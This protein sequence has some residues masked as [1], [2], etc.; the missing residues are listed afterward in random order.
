MDRATLTK[1]FEPFF[2]TKPVDKGTGLG[3]SQVYGFAKQS[4]GEIN[5]ESALG[6][7][8]TFT[9]YLPRSTSRTLPPRSQENES[10][11]SAFPRRRILLVEDNEAVGAFAADLLKELGQVVRWVGDGQSALDILRQD[12]ADYDLVFSDVVMPGISGIEL[13][14]AIA[15]EWPDLEVI[16]TSG[17]SH[18]LAEEGSFGFE[19]LKKPYSIDGLLKALRQDRST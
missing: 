11:A 3:L 9:L 1:I 10:G 15:T 8:T 4:G 6:S 13:A 12:D 5:A 17:Y 16:L 2:T 18:I 14:R 7:G 19:L